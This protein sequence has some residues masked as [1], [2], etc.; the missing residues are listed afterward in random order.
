MRVTFLGTAG[1][2]PSIER[3]PSAVLLEREGDRLLFDCGEGTQRQMMRYR[4]GFSIDAICIS[5]LHGDHILGIP[6]L[7]QTMDFN[8]RSAPLQVVAPPGGQPAIEEL[9]GVGGFRPSFPLELSTAA[10]GRPAIDAEDYS[11]IPVRTDHRGGPSV[12]YLLRE[13]SRLGR[14]DRTAAEALGVPPGP[15]FGQ[16][17]QGASVELE[18]G[19]VI[20]SE[21]VV[22]PSR[23]GRQVLYTGDSR[24]VGQFDEVS[25]EVD[26]MIHDAT[27][28]EA[29]V[30]RAET[31]GH[32][33][34]AQAAMD[35]VAND[36]RR[37]AL[38]HLSSRYG[39]DTSG[40]L[41][42]ARAA[43]PDVT[44]LAPADGETVEIP[45]RADGHV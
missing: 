33:T 11:V 25:G 43:A 44:V 9:I 35:A 28:A 7:L 30:A 22:G 10:A 41:A 13:A 29:D 38:I 17:H 16:L 4:T 31:T 26:L 36:A 24:P 32:S 42:E 27:F 14:F 5:H 8:G 39:G 21:E 40:V 34:A 6:G 15:L 12:G 37:L 2:L 1:A 3:A 20:H 19:Q 18:D 23:P 45:Y